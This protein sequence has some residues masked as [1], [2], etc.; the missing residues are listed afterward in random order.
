MQKKILFILLIFINLSAF[1]QTGLNL[2][3]C[4]AMT[5]N[6][7]EDLKIA[8]K[9][10]ET[11]SLQS[12]VVYANYLPKFSF[13]GT[14][15]LRN[16]ATKLKTDEQYFPTYNFDPSDSQLK[17]NLF[18]NPETNQTMIDEKGNPIFNQYAYLPAINEEVLPQS[19]LYASFSAEQAI[20][21]GGKIKTANQMAKIGEEMAEKNVEL[22]QAKLILEAD[23]SYWQYV[24]TKEKLKLAKQHLTL[25]KSLVKKLQDSYELK[26]VNKNELLKVQVKYNQAKLSLQRAKNG[27]EL[28]RMSLCRVVGLPLDHEIYVSDTIIKV[29]KLSIQENNI[30]KR[31]DYQLLEKKVLIEQKEIDLVRGDFLPQIG[32]SASYN[33]LQFELNNSNIHN[34]SLMGLLSVKVPIFNWKEGVNKIKIAQIEKEISELQFKKNTK[35][36]QLEANQASFNMQETIISLN[37]SEMSL[38]QADENLKISKDSYELG[39]ESLTNLLQAQT[40]WQ[41]AYSDFIDAKIECKLKQSIYLK[42]VGLLHT[43]MN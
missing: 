40:Q 22:Q 10:K 25:L 13:S 30:T 39:M 18:I 8:H 33:Y 20:Y 26:M 15:V 24:S 4:R 6:F 17:P 16:E 36:M 31:P 23:K 42:S 38:E 7:S 32:V 35:F 19:V 37:M 12:K 9:T 43:K 41:K 5:I 11:S 1:A 28:S 29:E 34:N 2:K 21:T 14:Y 3:K 27:L